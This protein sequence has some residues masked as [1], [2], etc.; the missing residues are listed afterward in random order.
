MWSN[1]RHGVNSGDACCKLL[2][3]NKNFR[4]F[5]IARGLTSLSLTVVSFYTIFGIRRYEMSP[6][7]V[8]G[9]TSVLLVTHTISSTVVWMGRRS[10]GTSPNIGV[11]Q[12]WLLSRLSSIALLAP[13]ASWFYVVFALTGI[14]NTTQWSTIM[15]ITVQFSSVSRTP[16]FYWHGQYIDRASDNIFA[17]HRRLASGCRELRVYFYDLRLWP[18]YCPCWCIAFLWKIRARR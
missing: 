14:V 18:A 10:L 8:G 16:L 17:Y 2:R 3:R 12:F 6:E 5:L 1:A 15:T 4:W 9:L 11:W 7:F 13:D